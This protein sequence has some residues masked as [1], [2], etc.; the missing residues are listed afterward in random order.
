MVL[1][2]VWSRQ[3]SPQQTCQTRQLT[4]LGIGQQG[5]NLVQLCPRQMQ[6]LCLLHRLFP[7]GFFTFAS[8]HVARG[9]YWRFIQRLDEMA[10]KTCVNSVIYARK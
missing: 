1:T 10:H 5:V 2:Q 3:S 6:Q 9:D 4:L 7:M 8:S